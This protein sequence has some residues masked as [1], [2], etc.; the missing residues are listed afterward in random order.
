[1]TKSCPKALLAV[2]LTCVAGATLE[3]GSGG[4]SSA[5]QPHPLQ[6]TS[7]HLVRFQGGDGTILTPDDRSKYTLQ[8]GADRRLAARIDCNR[9]SGIWKT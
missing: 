9:G 3:A 8:F 2:L 6:G 1:M 7:W 5:V 4:R